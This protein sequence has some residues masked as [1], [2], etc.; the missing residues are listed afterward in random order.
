[1]SSAVIRCLLLSFVS[2]VV[3]IV[4]R[5]SSILV[6]VV[7]RLSTVICHPSSVVCRP[8]SVIRHPSSIICRPS[9]I[10]RRPSSSILCLL[11][12]VRPSSVRRPSSSP[13]SSFHRPPSSSSFPWPQCKQTRVIAV[14][15]SVTSAVICQ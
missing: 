7:H 1:M 10:A 4:L 5:P 11:S 14:R 13:S 6:P 3:S 8:S 9:P 12:V 2:I 15:Q